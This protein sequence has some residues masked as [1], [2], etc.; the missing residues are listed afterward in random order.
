MSRRPVPLPLLLI[1][2]THQAQSNPNAPNDLT[3]IVGDAIALEWDVPT[4]RAASIPGTPQ[5]GETPTAGIPNAVDAQGLNHAA[6]TGY[7]AVGAAA[8]A[9]IQ[10]ARG[11]T[12][13]LPDEAEDDGRPSK[14]AAR[15]TDHRHDQET[16]AGATGAHLLDPRRA[17]PDPPL[18][19]GTRDQRDL[20]A[21]RSWR[22]DAG[23]AAPASNPER[24]AEAAWQRAAPA[25]RSGHYRWARKPAAEP[26]TSI[27]TGAGRSSREVDTSHG[28]TQTDSSRNPQFPNGDTP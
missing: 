19:A 23:T 11:T 21:A 4:Q 5:V 22:P 3:A 2:W 12:C 13:S 10:D 26:E 14:A 1:P 25:S 20:A 27:R 16:L 28:Q 15:F 9:G 24:Q 8:N 6:F 18:E 17:P 7:R